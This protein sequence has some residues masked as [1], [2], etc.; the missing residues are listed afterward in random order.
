[1][2]TVKLASN[3]CVI[4]RE[5]GGGRELIKFYVVVSIQNSIILSPM[6]NI[7]CN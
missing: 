1:M 4:K 2:K 3:L 6:H 5:G 7:L